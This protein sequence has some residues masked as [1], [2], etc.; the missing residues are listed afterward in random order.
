[1]CIYTNTI[2]SVLKLDALSTDTAPRALMYS[3]LVAKSGIVDIKIEQR[4]VIAKGSAG[5][6]K[7]KWMA[8]R[9]KHSTPDKA[10]FV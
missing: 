5:E 9:E 1:M 3:S 10:A 6:L 4:V 7:S 8:E 2:P